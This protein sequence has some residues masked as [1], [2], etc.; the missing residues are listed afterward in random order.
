MAEARLQECRAE[1][2]RVP[3]NRPVEQPPEVRTE[4]DVTI[5]PVVEERLVVE[6]RLVLTEEIHVR[7][8][9]AERVVSEPVM[10][11]RQVAEVE[12]APAEAPEPQER[13]HEHNEQ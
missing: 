12:R 2:T 9:Q 8:V 11:R 3:V 5:I 13:G 1:I 6:R 7:R 10:L 4:G